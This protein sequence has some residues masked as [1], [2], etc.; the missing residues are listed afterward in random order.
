MPTVNFSRPEDI[1]KIYRLLEAKGDLFTDIKRTS[2]Y[3][4]F[5]HRELRLYSNKNAQGY[6]HFNI[7]K[8]QVT[9]LLSHLVR[10]DPIFCRIRY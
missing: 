2:H 7:Y 10:Q 4:L 8:I 9:K 6:C 3:Q 1:F 5:F